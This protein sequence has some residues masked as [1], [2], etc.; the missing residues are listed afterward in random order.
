MTHESFHDLLKQVQAGDEASI[1]L[2]LSVFEKEIRL[3]V[4]H[5]LP[6]RLRAR[7][8]SMDFVQSVYQSILADW[9]VQPPVQFQNQAQVRSYLQGIATNKVLEMYR[10][11]TRTQKYDISR[12][13]SGLIRGTASTTDD[14]D[15]TTAI[16]P[17]SSDPTPSKHLQAKDLME[18]LTRGRPAVV[19]TILNLRNEGRTFEEIGGI[20]G[21]SERS[22]R[23]M[24]NDLRDQVQESDE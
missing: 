13:V 19:A 8:D 10:R 23:R 1:G 15:R 9:R 17:P 7:Y 4:R 2:L 21:L 24:V 6:R 3:I 18:K 11:E 14:L 22:I 12:E 5:K 20:V 16:D